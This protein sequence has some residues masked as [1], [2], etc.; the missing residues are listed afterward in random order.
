VSPADRDQATSTWRPWTRDP[1]HR[2]TV[3]VSALQGRLREAAATIGGSRL[4]VIALYAAELV[5]QDVKVALQGIVTQGF[6]IG[7]QYLDRQ[8]PCGLGGQD[9]D[10]RYLVHWFVLLARVHAFEARLLI[11]SVD[12]SYNAASLKWSGDDGGSRSS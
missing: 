11:S 1:G 5:P 4:L 9:Y 10:L 3:P 12:L 2:Q 8:K 7:K 6:G